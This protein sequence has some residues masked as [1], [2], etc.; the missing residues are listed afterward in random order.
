M[1]EQLDATRAGYDAVAA[2]YAR[3]VTGLAG[4][5]ELEQAMLVVLARLL[6]R[7]DAPAG[8]VADVGCGTGRLTAHLH[9]LG[10]DAFGIDLSPGMLAQART[11]HPALRFTTGTVTGLDLPDDSCAGALSWYSLLHLPPEHLPQALGELARVLR[12]GGLLLLGF[13]VG[14]GHRV[15][16]GAYGP[17]VDIDAWDI[18][19]ERAVELATGAGLQVHTRLQ[20]RPLGRER[21]EQASLLCRKPA[22]A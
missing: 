3:L 7:E 19:L 9:D 2:D 15:I 17:P 12:P 10:L 13:H 21:R 20:R 8:P 5:S 16:S 4:E 14:S 11:A 18:T 1:Q 22:R 6:Q